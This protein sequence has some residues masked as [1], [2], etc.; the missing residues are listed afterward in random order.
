[1]NSSFRPARTRIAIAR[2]DHGATR[3]SHRADF[4]QAPADA[5][6]SKKPLVD[7]IL[8]VWARVDVCGAAGTEC[9]ALERSP[10]T[11]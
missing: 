3:D 11:Y 2:H 4:H 8:V 7:T 5:R 10:P 9:L 1:M 6:L